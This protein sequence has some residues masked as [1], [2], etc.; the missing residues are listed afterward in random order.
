[1]LRKGLYALFF[2]LFACFFKE[3]I[4]DWDVQKIADIFE[5]NH[6]T[7]T[8]VVYDVKADYLLMYNEARSHQLFYPASTFKIANS[9]IGLKTKVV[10]DEDEVFYHYDGYSQFFLKEWEKDASLRSG[11]KVS[12]VPAFQ[13][14]ARRIGLQNMQQELNA[15]DY[16]N[17]EIGNNVE[18]FWLNGPL[19]ISAVQQAYFLSSLAQGSLPY[20]EDVQENVRS[21]CELEQGDGWILYGK[22]GLSS[23]EDP[24]VGWFVGWVD[25]KGRLYSFALNMDM[26]NGIQQDLN[27]RIDL[28]KASLH[29]LEII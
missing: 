26:G 27:K 25:K 9:L 22:T 12:H 15:L 21:I 18:N 4:P 14:L 20:P 28:A 19:K 3:P 29:A 11:I 5:Q 17:R 6:T 1:M 16:G 7:G 8:F 23:A 10:H 24:Q 2:I 13:E